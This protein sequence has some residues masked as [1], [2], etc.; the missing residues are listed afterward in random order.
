M[1]IGNKNI[2]MNEKWYEINN[3][4][5]KNGLIRKNTKHKIYKPYKQKYFDIERE[6]DGP[7]YRDK[8]TYTDEDKDT[9][10]THIHLDTESNI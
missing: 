2:L 9:Y 4:Y 3:I 7:A 1:H 6:E 8:D 5:H 10:K